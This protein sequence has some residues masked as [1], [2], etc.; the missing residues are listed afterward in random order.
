[1]MGTRLRDSGSYANLPPTATRE[2]CEREAVLCFVLRH[3]RR[4]LPPPPP[5]VSVSLK[6]KFWPLDPF[7]PISNMFIPEGFPAHPHRGFQTVTY[8][9]KVCMLRREGAERGTSRGR[10]QMPYS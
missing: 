8:A 9:M 5:L 7:R 1:M 10:T 3:F 2:G 4:S 6:L